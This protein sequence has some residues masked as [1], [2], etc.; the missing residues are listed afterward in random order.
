[1]PPAKPSAA[2][3]HPYPMGQMASALTPLRDYWQGLKRGNATMPF[4]DDVQL[5]ALTGPAEIMLLD[6][7]D[8]PQRF[9]FAIVGSDIARIYGADLAG[10]FVDEIALREPLDDFLSQCAATVAAHAPTLY[11]HVPENA[12]DGY[13]RLLLPF[14]GD[15]HIAALLCGFVGE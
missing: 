13:Q 6:V 7:F 5:G 15:G 12:P 11:R 1:M 2:A 10:C 3:K 9:R 8:H 4:A 14:W